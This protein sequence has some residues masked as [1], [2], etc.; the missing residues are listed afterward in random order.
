MAAK[1][2]RG[3]EHLSYEER[4]QCFGIL[5]WKKCNGKQNLQCNPM[6]IYSDVPLHSAELACRKICNLTLIELRMVWRKTIFSPYFTI[7]ELGHHPMKLDE[8]DLG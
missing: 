7:L 8:G 1:M 5:A 6:N 3:L 4:L 2:I